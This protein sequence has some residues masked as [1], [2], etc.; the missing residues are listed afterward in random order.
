MKGLS[1]SETSTAIQTRLEELQMEQVA[2]VNRL[3]SLHVPE[4]LI[5]A[6]TTADPVGYPEAKQMIISWAMNEW[7]MTRESAL[8]VLNGLN[9][10]VQQA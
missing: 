10:P 7:G 1:V 8:R 4:E 2:D 6:A 5:T 3:Q 9:E